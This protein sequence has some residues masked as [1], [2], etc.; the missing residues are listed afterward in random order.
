MSPATRQLQAHFL[1]RLL[2]HFRQD[3]DDL[4]L[5]LIMPSSDMIEDL[6]ASQQYDVGLAETPVPRAEDA[7]ARARV[8]TPAD[9]EG[10]PMAVLF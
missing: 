8:I 5:S 4:D 9:L 10:R 7:L 6:I 3:H 1:P 2:T